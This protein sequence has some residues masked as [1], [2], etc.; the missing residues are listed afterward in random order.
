MSYDFHTN[1]IKIKDG[2]LKRRIRRDRQRE[3]RRVRRRTEDGPGH[4]P[5]AASRSS[6]PGRPDHLT[7][8]IRLVSTSDPAVIR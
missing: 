1:I 3:A 7:R 4:A 6:D 8:V 5:G 2:P